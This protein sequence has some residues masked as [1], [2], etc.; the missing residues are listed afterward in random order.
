MRS[1]LFQQFIIENIIIYI[2][3]DNFNNIFFSN[4]LH[5]GIEHLK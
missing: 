2:I 4:L 5:K 3:C 1:F